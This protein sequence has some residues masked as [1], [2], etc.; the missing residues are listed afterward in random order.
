MT[1]EEGAKYPPIWIPIG[2]KYLTIRSDDE[3]PWRET[4]VMDRLEDMKGFTADE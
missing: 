3:P 1:A 2:K 4:P